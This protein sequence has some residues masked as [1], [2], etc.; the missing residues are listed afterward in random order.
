VGPRRSHW[1]LIVVTL[2]LTAYGTILRRLEETFAARRDPL[3]WV[4]RVEFL[5]RG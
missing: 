2:P 5:G 1:G 4:D 3:E